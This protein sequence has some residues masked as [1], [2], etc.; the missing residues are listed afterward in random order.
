MRK[1]T[2]T[3][4]KETSQTSFLLLSLS[5]MD[6]LREFPFTGTTVGVFTYDNDWYDDGQ[7]F[8]FSPRCGESLQWKPFPSVTESQ[9]VGWPSPPALQLS[10]SVLPALNV[11]RPHS[12]S[13]FHGSDV[14]VGVPDGVLFWVVEIDGKGGDKSHHLYISD[15]TWNELSVP[16]THHD[17]VGPCV[18]TSYAVSFFHWLL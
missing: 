3:A 4:A 13:C 6:C 10:Q 12:L 7:H 8:S 17:S 16:K 5:G 18:T 1:Y 9:S 2:L 14:E 15:T 11:L